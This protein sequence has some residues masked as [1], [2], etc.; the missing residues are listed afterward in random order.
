MGKTSSHYNAMYIAFKRY[1]CNNDR[2][3]QVIY[4]QDFYRCE[5]GYESAATTLAHI[6]CAKLVKDMHYE[7]HV[8]VVISYNAN[9]LKVKVSK[10]EAR[11]MRLTKEQYMQVHIEHY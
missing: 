10:A 7:A 11:N 6:V 9:F 4:M 5:S 1:S 3:C 8:Q 2:I